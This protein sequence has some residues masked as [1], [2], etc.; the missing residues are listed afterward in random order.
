ML[1]FVVY[2]FIYYKFKIH[3]KYTEGFIEI[4]YIRRLSKFFPTVNS[5]NLPHLNLELAV[6]RDS[7]TGE[8]WTLVL[9]CIFLGLSSRLNLK[10]P[11]NITT[12]N[13]VH[14]RCWRKRESHAARYSM[15]PKNVIAYLN[16]QSDNRTIGH[17]RWENKCIYIRKWIEEIQAY[18]KSNNIKTPLRRQTYNMRE[19]L[20]DRWYDWS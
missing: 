16:G 1:W 10:I 2:C 7:G 11:I 3:N 12:I 13:S 9:D 15:I 4:I 8:S 17:I 19:Y 20:V 6:E 18:V 14:Y 5:T